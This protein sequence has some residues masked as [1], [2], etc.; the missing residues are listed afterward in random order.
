MA[1]EFLAT[2]LGWY[3]VIFSVFLLLRGA[4]VPVVM[5]EILKQKGV[6][7]LMSVITVILGLLMVISHNIWVMG[8]PVI[9]TVFSWLVLISGLARLFFPEHL[10][11]MGK[12]FIAN[13]LHL[14]IAAIVLLV[15]G[16]CLLYH[17]YRMML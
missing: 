16:A 9:V 4:L 3:L 14:R 15:I 13:P 7:F 2:V 5:G 11:T 8:W 10:Q 12:A 17:V 6:F 1:T